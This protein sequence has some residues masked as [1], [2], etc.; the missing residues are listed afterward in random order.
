MLYRVA[1]AALSNVVQH[2]KAS[3]V[4]VRVCKRP[5]AVRL[6]IKDDG[7]GFSL[8]DGFPSTQ[9]ERLGLLGMKERLEMVGGTFNLDS[10]PGRG[11]T[12][13]AEIPLGRSRGRAR[14]EG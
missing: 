10:E 5:G 6:E 11:T 14:A 7:I 9:R 13:G 4:E 8:D 12:I 3:R 1:Q 2:A